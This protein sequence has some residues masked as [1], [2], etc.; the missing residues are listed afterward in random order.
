MENQITKVNEIYQLQTISAPL[1]QMTEDYGF[2][3]EAEE[4]AKFA[5]TLRHEHN[6][7]E[8][9]NNGWFTF[10]SESLEDIQKLKSLISM[11]K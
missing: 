9:D 8:Y 11:A 7:K 4:F 2:T 3:K 10:Y 6:M 5:K 1:D